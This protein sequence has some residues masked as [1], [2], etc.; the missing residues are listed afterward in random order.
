MIVKTW[1]NSKHLDSDFNLYGFTLFRRD[2][3]CRKAVRNSIL[4][5]VF[6]RDIVF[7]H[8]N[9]QIMWL[10]IFAQRC[11]L[12]CYIPPNPIHTFDMFVPQLSAVIESVLSDHTN[13]NICCCG[14]FQY[15]VCTDFVVNNYGL[16]QLVDRPAHGQNIL[17]KFCLVNLTSITPLST[18][19]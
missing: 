1:F 15:I 9:V 17:D 7:T 10:K 8:S 16:R 12:L 18:A 14:R 3:M 2:R 5:S 11:F 4:C 6:Q 19:V 13:L